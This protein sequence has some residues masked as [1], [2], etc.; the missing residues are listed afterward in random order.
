MLTTGRPPA[1]R[2]PA[3]G[4]A[5]ADG[6]Y[7]PRAPRETLGPLGQRAAAAGHQ[8]KPSRA[9]GPVQHG[10]FD[11]ED[12][13]RRR[14]VGAVAKQLQRL[15]AAFQRQ[16]RVPDELDAGIAQLVEQGSRLGAQQRLSA[17]AAAAALQPEDFHSPASSP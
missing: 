11:T 13:E 14:P 2:K 6:E 9:V 17:A 4:S 3:E 10:T 8:V 16:R 7:P 12:V 1:G 15:G 5:R